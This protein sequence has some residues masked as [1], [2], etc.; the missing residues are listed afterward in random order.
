MKKIIEHEIITP[1]T[2]QHNKMAGRKNISILN[3]ASAC[4]RLDKC[5][6][7]FGKKQPQQKYILSINSQQKI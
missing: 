2:P 5:K 6:V 1:Y 4:L 3:M 7:T